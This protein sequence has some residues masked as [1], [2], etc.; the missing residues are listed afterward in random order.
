M[1]YRSLIMR[2]LSYGICVWGR[3]A[4]SYISKLLVLQ[5]SALR[6]IYFAPRDTHAV[7]LFIE[8][9]ILPVNMI[10]FDMVANLMHDIWKGL[11]PSPIRALFTKSN[12]I[13]GYKTRHAAKGNYIRKEVLTSDVLFQEL[14]Q[15]YGIKFL[16]IGEIYLSQPL[17]KKFANFYLRLFQIGMTMLKSTPQFKFLNCS[18]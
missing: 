3:A 11:T 5:K 18:A 2:Y 13:H 8:S 16:Q 6:L 14:E 7:P 12:E 15:C 9:K 1:I 4:K 17:R 10:Y